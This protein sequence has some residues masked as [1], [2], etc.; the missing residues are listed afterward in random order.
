MIYNEHDLLD[1]VFTHILMRVPTKETQA[2]Q[3]KLA[4]YE[5]CGEEIRLAARAMASMPFMILK[6]KNPLLYVESDII[7]TVFSVS[8]HFKALAKII[9]NGYG[10]LEE[11]NVPYTGNPN[12]SREI[13]RNIVADKE[14]ARGATYFALFALLEF[15][16]AVPLQEHVD[17]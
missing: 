5:P 9:A 4:N 8:G 6:R 7:A 11:I 13:E 3:G 2:A 1:V 10:G 17:G 15:I 14:A 12:L 16:T